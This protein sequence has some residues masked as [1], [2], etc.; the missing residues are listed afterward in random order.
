MIPRPHVDWFALSPELALLGVASLALMAA[1][2]LPARARKP[3]AA[4]V[5]ALGYA[6]AGIA[7]GFL[8]DRSAHGG[9]TIADAVF[10]DR[11]G[12]LAQIILAGIGVVAVGISYGQRSRSEHVA[13]YYALLAAAGGGMMFFVTAGNLMTLFLGLEWFSICLYILCAV[14]GERVA[15]LEAGLKYLIVGGFG[16]AVLLFG[17]ALVSGSSGALGWAEIAK[18]D[19]DDAMLVIGLAMVIAGLAFKSSAAPFHMWTPDV[20]EGAPT[21]V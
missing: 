5:T 11:W 18:A 8:Y 3:F 6:G 16:S 12:A 21:P 10:R 17:S 13:E 1:V 15:S 2:L 14:E 9:P 4:V 20:Y 19:S 7:A